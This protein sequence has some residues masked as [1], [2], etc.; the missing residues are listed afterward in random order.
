MIPAEGRDTVEHNADVSDD[1]IKRQIASQVDNAVNGLVISKRISGEDAEHLKTALYEDI[2]HV[3]R[4]PERQ[5][6]SVTMKAHIGPLPDPS[7]LREY[8][9]LCPGTAKV[10][11]ESVKRDGET[12]RRNSTIKVFMALFGQLVVCV[13]GLSGLYCG[14]KLAMA[15]KDGAS[16][17]AIFTGLGVMLASIVGRKIIAPPKDENKE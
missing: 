12:R 10:F 9:N 14:Y 11:V 16:I 7:V 13:I 8:E 4:R 3:M 15:G 6:M 17:S 5:S 1:E 2:I